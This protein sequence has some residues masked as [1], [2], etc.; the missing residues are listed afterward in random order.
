M[1]QRI[2]TAVAANDATVPS[3]RANGPAVK[4]L[5]TFLHESAMPWGRPDHAGG[6]WSPQ[7]F[8]GKCRRAYDYERAQLLGQGALVW[9]SP[10]PAVP[11]ESG[12]SWRQLASVER[13]LLHYTYS[14]TSTRE[15]M[16]DPV[17]FQ[18]KVAFVWKVADKLRGTFKQH[19]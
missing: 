2:N 15:G 19:E 1:P 9:P 7:L 3:W 13:C 12:S 5:E 8:C 4:P 10:V 11:S 17:G 14:A 6:P 16:D 18:D